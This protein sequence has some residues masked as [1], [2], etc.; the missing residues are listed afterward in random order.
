MKLAHS[1]LLG[2]YVD[3]AQ[4]EHADTAGFQ[5]VCPCCAESVFKVERGLANG[6]RSEF[7][8]HR[9]APAYQA[10]GCELR[11]SAI[12]AEERAARNESSRNQSLALFRQWMRDALN[13]N[14]W[15]YGTWKPADVHRRLSAMPMG[16]MLYDILR[17]E[18]VRLGAGN[19]MADE[20]R[21]VREG[22][23]EARIDFGT[24]FGADIQDRIVG[25]MMR[26]LLSPEGK[27]NH[28]YLYRHT[29]TR[30]AFVDVVTRGVQPFGKL[31][32][33]PIPNDV[34]LFLKASMTKNPRIARSLAAES[35]RHGDPRD[36][37]RIYRVMT[38]GMLTDLARLPFAEMLAN[39]RAGRPAL[40]G[41]VPVADPDELSGI[42]FSL[43]PDEA[44]VRA[45]A[46]SR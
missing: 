28:A 4:V 21:Q 34:S 37:D 46:F 26:H 13:L 40:S 3:A 12:P 32:G 7:F 41:I 44:P 1:I 30:L 6:G 45:G 8:S 10:A 39:H 36:S 17:K 9:Q 14:A 22:A 18:Q 24:K 33:D 38:M 42:K 25:D 23:K 5:I 29:L 16:P 20:M 31:R 11:V 2:E 15:L 19:L 43:L 35:H 27:A